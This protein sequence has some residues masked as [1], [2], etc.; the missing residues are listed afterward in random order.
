MLAGI[1]RSGITMVAGLFRGL[2]YEDAAR[3]SFLL[4]TP[5]I[6]LAGI[7]KIPD[8]LGTLGDGVR[9]QALIGAL[10]AFAGALISVAFLDPVLQDS[11]PLAIRAVLPRDGHLLHRPL[12]LTAALAWLRALHD[13]SVPSSGR[14]R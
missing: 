6:L 1:S 14:D 9:N 13:T 10:C 3:F 8:L 4:A 12:R 7:F 11:N 5:I 2:D